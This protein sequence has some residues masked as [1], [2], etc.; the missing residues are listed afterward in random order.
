M[1]KNSNINGKA[2]K[3]DEEQIFDLK[4][5]L[6]KLKANWWVFILSL[7]VFGIFGVLF[8]YYKAPAYNIVSTLLIDNGSSNA[9]SIASSSSSLLDISS[10]LDLKNNVDNEVQVLQTR[11]LMAKTVRD[12]N[13]NVIYYQQRLITDLEINRNP[14]IVK[15]IKPVDTIMTTKFYFSQVDKNHFEIAYKVTYPDNST[16]RKDGTFRYGAYIK[17][18]GVGIIQV[19]KNPAFDFGKYDYRFDIESVDQRVYELQQIL[20]ITTTSTTVTTINMVFDYPIPREGEDI[21]KTLTLNYQR[22]NVQLKNQVADSTVSFIDRRL[23]IVGK[24]LGGVETNI[25]N[26]KQNN[27]LI[28]DL[29]EQG[30]VLIENT[31]SYTDQLAKNE[32]QLSIVQSLLEYLKDENK[33]KTVVPVSVLPNDLVLVALINNYNQ[34]LVERDRQLLSVTKDNPFMENL[35]DRIATLRKDMIK[36]LLTTQKT[37]QI[38]DQQLR[39]KTN[40]F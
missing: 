14:I 22:Q 12:M 20:S 13:L 17:V 7:G 11:H 39:G 9:S 30:K 16:E 37:L 26:F 27:K 40:Q 10:L 5:F 3:E 34:L 36:N 25:Q 31:S 32:T 33:N 18:V 29:T 38:T 15:V 6:G 21:L 4:G 24:E 1:V 28:G 2:L 8:M 23:K 35:E 19:T